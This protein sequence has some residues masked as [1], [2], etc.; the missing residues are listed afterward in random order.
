M[1]LNGRSFIFLPNPRTSS[2][3]FLQDILKKKGATIVSSFEDRLQFNSKKVIILIDD[4]FVD[5]QMHLT[6]RDIFKREAGLNDIDDFLTKI[7]ESNIQCLKIS[8]I[9][10]WVE[11]EK[12]TI[13]KDYLIKMRPSI[14]TISDDTDDGQSY[15]DKDSEVSTDVEGKGNN[16]SKSEER[17]ETPQTSVHSLKLDERTTS[18][19]TNKTMYKNNELIITAL[20]K[21]TKKCEIKGERFRA[22]SYKLAKQSLENC[23]FDV[24]SGEEAHIK[25]KNIGPSIAKKI[26]VIL[27]TGGLPGLNDS[28]GL[29]DKL[30]YFK[31]C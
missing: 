9:T 17:L 30:K 22:R 12:F 3:K 31:N 24:R 14:I 1:S 10:K 15:N 20:K 8:Y 27:D 4:S 18:L 5:S 6:Q 2:N 7:E 23:D 21:L 19:V 13:E 29:E 16:G 26:Q 28:M 11:S 25:L